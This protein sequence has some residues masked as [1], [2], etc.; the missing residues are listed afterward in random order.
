M[1]AKTRKRTRSSINEGGKGKSSVRDVTLG[2]TVIAILKEHMEAERSQRVFLLENSLG[3]PLDLGALAKDVIR[4]T[5]AAA[6]L[7]WKGYYGGH[8][9]RKPR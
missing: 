3:V 1:F 8:A 5:F 4:P 7:E 6:G 2:P 9:E